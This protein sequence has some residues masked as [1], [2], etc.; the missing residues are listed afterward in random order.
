MVDLGKI[1]YLTTNNGE[2]MLGLPK[3]AIERYS[4]RLSEL[5]YSLK[6]REVNPHF[7][8]ESD[9]PAAEDKSVNH[10]NFV[11]TDNNLGVGGAKEKFKRNIE[12]VKILKECEAAGRAASAEEQEALSQYVGWGGLADA[13]D[14]DKKN[15]AE[16]YEQLKAILTE[17]EYKSAIKSTQ[18][19]FYTP[20]EVIKAIYQAIGNTGITVNSILEPACGTGNFMGMIP[21]KLEDAKMYGVELD[22]VSGRIAKMLYPNNNIQ[23]C[24]YEDTQF[25]DN[26]FDVAVGNVPFGQLSVNDRRYSNHKFMI[27]DYY[28]AKTIDKVR[29]G[30]IIAFITSK[31][32]MD[33]KNSSVRKY[34]AQRADLL[35]AVRLP[36][37]TFNH[38]IEQWGNEF[39]QLYPSANILVSSKKDFEKSNRQ[40]FFS[41]IAMGEY[42]AVIVGHSQFEKIPLSNERLAHNLE[43]EI[44]R[45]SAAIEEMRGDDNVRLSVKQMERT[46]QNLE[47]KYKSLLDNGRKDDIFSFENLGVDYLFVD[48]AHM[49][50]NCMV[51]TKL[52][53]VSGISVT[54]AQKSMDML[55][56]CKYLS[57]LQDGRGVVFATGTPI[58][59]SITE[60][61]IMQRYLD[62]KSLI[63]N[64]LE[65]F[66][67]WAAMFGNVTSGL[68]LAPEGTG[69]RMKSRLSKFDNLPELM[70]MFTHF[71]DVQSSQMLK[72]P[73]PD[74]TVHNEVVEPDEFIAFEMM[75]YVERAAAIRSGTIDPSEDNMLKI[76][77]EARKL[78]LDPQ[79]I[80]PDAPQSR[81]IELCADNI[82]KEY[83]AANDIKGTQ[84][85][86]CD[87]GTPQADEDSTYSRLINSLK[88]RGIPE[89]EI[90]V[91]HDANTDAKKSDM[92]AKVRA[93]IYRVMIGSTQKMGA[94]TN[95]QTRLTALHH[96]DCPWRSSD[97][98]Q[99]EGR[100][101]RQGNMNEH[102][103]I[104]RYVT[105][106]TF[107][108]YMWQT[109][110]NKQRFI[111]QIMTGTTT[112]RSCEDMDETVLSFAE[113][114]ACA[115]GDERIKE[116]MELEI[117]TQRLQVMKSAYYRNKIKYENIVNKFPAQKEILSKALEKVNK[118]III[119]DQNRLEGFQIELNGNKFDKRT[120]AGIFL[121]KLMSC[122][123]ENE[124]VI[125]KYRG[126]QLCVQ[127]SEI[128]N[129]DIYSMCQKNMLLRGEGA[130]TIES[131]FSELGNISRIE[132]LINN[133]E[134][135]Q[136]NYQNKLETSETEYS[137]ANKNLNKP[138]L[139][140]QE[141]QEALSR[142]AVLNRE[143]NMEEAEQ[144]EH[145]LEEDICM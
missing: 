126:F 65:F 80:D 1:N 46:K 95:C 70:N 102:V 106:N 40:K 27:H 61:Y 75:K 120:E 84:L 123:G 23:I 51:T 116:K 9:V 112:A 34:I 117:K 67:S 69:Y 143:L 73:V 44:D 13:F 60:M 138:F 103:N 33:K 90:A 132:N 111:T 55:F 109:V 141:L 130:Y 18:T 37:N 97:I 63:E 25:P 145:P 96:I 4:D 79:L 19:A 134:K 54:P 86:F 36:D 31:F 42:D 2:P 99:R 142:L 94:G 110:E 68:E 93:G 108:A 38:L 71:A 45:L 35:G 21:E 127:S 140:E 48:E 136:Q 115:T 144:I 119:R 5:G 47:E 129:I 89:D 66:D 85:V 107:D 125:G 14:K 64:G 6:T 30:G 124:E 91:I 77:N 78:A 122:S 3:H 29:P 98:E 11:I 113:I 135:Y 20:P 32:T 28:F 139:Q 43:E 105:K 12:A 83:T 17:S 137:E 114:K 58:S 41:K 24:G 10:Q 118:D 104:Y 26:F 7:D 131:S 72:L 8:I 128:S 39:L 22:S 82:Y 15:W 88:L 49:Y 76:T 57:E 52:Q 133:L 87:L 56:K 62:N 59:N 121:H 81:K 100:I 101:L 92:F 16:E 53:N 74:H 50:K